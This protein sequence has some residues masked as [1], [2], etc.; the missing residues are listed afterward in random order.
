VDR[1]YRRDLFGG[2]VCFVD[3][4]GLREERWRIC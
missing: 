2:P 3:A 4:S 1:G